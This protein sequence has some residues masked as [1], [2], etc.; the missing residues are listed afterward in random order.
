MENVFHWDQ[1]QQVFFIFVNGFDLWFYN[2][3]SPFL[4]TGSIYQA[5]YYSVQFCHF[6]L[7][8]IVLERD[9]FLGIGY[10]FAYA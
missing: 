3:Q 1:Y 8:L 6:S 2:Q 10:P 5:N 7:G 9:E 4:F